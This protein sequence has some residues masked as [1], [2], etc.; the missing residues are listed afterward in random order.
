MPPTPQSSSAPLTMYPTTIFFNHHHPLF[1]FLFFLLLSSSSLPSVLSSSCSLKYQ[2]T[3]SSQK[4]F[5][6]CI[7]LGSQEATLAYTYFSRNSSVDLV[8]SGNFISPAGWVGWGINPITAGQMV[9]ANVLIAFRDPTTTKPILL[10]YALS[11]SVKSQQSTLVSSTFTKPNITSSSLLII[12]TK[13]QIFATLTLLP[14]QTKLNHIWNHGAYVQ[15]YSP[16]IHPTSPADLAT[17]KTIDVKTST[18]SGRGSA[19]A[20]TTRLRTAHATLNSLSWGFLLILGAVSAR[21]LRHQLP[22]SD[23]FWFYA[24]VG[25]QMTG[26]AAGVAG[27]ATGMRLGS[28]SEGVVHGLHRKL[29]TALFCLGTLQMMAM[30]FRPKK[31]HKFRKYWKSYHHLVGYACVVVAVVNVFQGFDVMQ[32]QAGSPAKMAYCLVLST[33]VGVCVALEVNGWLLFL[34]RN[35]EQHSESDRESADYDDKAGGWMMAHSC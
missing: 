19:A 10:P 7:K 32:L 11:S 5:E 9:G 4:T 29:G 23:P 24:H 8:F 1:F 14:N 20:Y 34:R 21:Y 28:L 13:V 2:D 3:S 33:I 27:W 25:L 15:G 6:N 17:A 12:G 30:F 18:I 26:Y 22:S 31:T 16:T 35:R